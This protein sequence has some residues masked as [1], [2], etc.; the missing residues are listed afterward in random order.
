M[1][2]NLT[3]LQT[4]TSYS[5]EESQLTGDSDDEDFERY[6]FVNSPNDSKSFF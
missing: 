1:N 4:S 6:Q 3:H 2:Q 5:N